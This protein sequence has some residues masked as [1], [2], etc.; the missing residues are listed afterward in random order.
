MPTAW[1][2]QSYDAQ[3][4]STQAA[5]MVSQ[6]SGTLQSAGY[7]VI[8]TTTNSSFTL[9]RAPA[10]DSYWSHPE[11]VLLGA[12][13]GTIF[14]VDEALDV[15]V[16]QGTWAN[17]SAVVGA[18]GVMSAGTWPNGAGPTVGAL[19]NDAQNLGSISPT[20]GVAFTF[21]TWASEYGLLAL[22]DNGGTP[23]LLFG[24]RPTHSPT[25]PRSIEIQGQGT[26]PLSVASPVGSSHLVFGI[27]GQAE[28][29]TLPTG[30]LSAHRVVQELN[31]Q[32]RGLAEARIEDTFT[33]TVIAVRR[34][35]S[36]PTIFGYSSTRPKLALTYIDST[37]DTL[38]FSIFTGFA[39]SVSTTA[40]TLNGVNWVSLG[41]RIGATI[42][43]R[44]KGAGVLVTGFDTDNTVDDTLLATIP[45]TWNLADTYCVLPGPEDHGT[46][47]HQHDGYWQACPETNSATIAQTDGTA[48]VILNDTYGEA[49]NQYQVGQHA[50][51]AN[52]AYA[53]VLTLGSTSGFLRGDTVTDGVTGAQGLIR[54]VYTADDEIVVDTT[55]GA[56]SLG[57]NAAAWGANAIT[58]SS[59]GVDTIA[60]VRS[61]T[62][63]STV[64]WFQRAEVTSVTQVDTANGDYRTVLEL[65]LSGMNANTVLN[66]GFVIAP[67][68]KLQ[69][70][71]NATA[72]ADPVL[73]GYSRTVGA[74]NFAN[75]VVR[76]DFT[77]LGAS[78]Q[79]YEPDYET[80]NLVLGEALVRSVTPFGVDLIGVVPH[81]R[82]VNGRSAFS[83]GTT[84]D[85][86]GDFNRRWR[87]V[88]S[89][90]NGGWGTAMSGATTLRYAVGPGPE[91]L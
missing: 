54:E 45:G 22:Y 84:L 38:G 37:V 69:L 8:H 79:K 68:A 51:C 20:G 73:E 6:M 71:T 5:R 27:D 3:I 18:S 72:A 34:T 29:V 2:Q 24:F 66:P 48:T 9:F 83:I 87:L 65:D 33:G 12:S 46:S 64:G 1:D 55:L 19:A 14:R 91:T 39:D 25:R 26:F 31:L 61:A 11:C 23:I 77:A 57:F 4:A 62:D 78:A 76:N 44:S 41:V 52:N 13:S 50:M 81:L 30:S 28:S 43:N 35:S 85:E 42:W 88:T 80:G 53:V 7:T 74:W 56:T 21:T 36:M 15:D 17:Q 60:S 82:A 16:Q 40:L 47:A 86:D 75:D 32:L 89:Q 10:L 58:S 63:D 90:T 70:G 49:F 67:W 59:G